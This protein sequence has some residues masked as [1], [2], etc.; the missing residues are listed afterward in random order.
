MCASWWHGWAAS[1]QQRRS[2]HQRLPML[3]ST[4]KNHSDR[5]LSVVDGARGPPLPV[6]ISQTRTSESR[7]TILVAAEA[8]LD[9]QLSPVSTR[10]RRWIPFDVDRH[11][12]EC[13]SARRHHFRPSAHRPRSVSST[14]SSSQALPEITPHRRSPRCHEAS[15]CDSH[16]RQR[17]GQLH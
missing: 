7:P 9:Q 2:A 6:V 5:R 16:Q 8:V 1:S 15:Q 4:R 13:L 11:G 14:K 12:A 3:P 10:R 17:L